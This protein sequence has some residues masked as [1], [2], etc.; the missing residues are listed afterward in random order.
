MERGFGPWVLG[1]WF[2]GTAPQA[3][4]E[5]AFGPGVA[6]LRWSGVASEPISKLAGWVVFGLA[7]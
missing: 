3:V 7:R 4:M 2:P 6:W 1:G 5:R